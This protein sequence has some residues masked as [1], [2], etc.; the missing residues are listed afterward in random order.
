MHEVGI[1]LVLLIVFLFSMFA[2]RITRA[3]LTAPIFFLALGLAFSQS[4]IVEVHAAHDLLHFLA[5]VTLVI[6]LFLDAAQIDLKKLRRFQTWPM[7]ML[8]IGLPLAVFIGAIGNWLIYPEWPLVVTVLVAAL[9]APTDAALGQAVITNA[10]VPERVRTTITVESGLN[11][12]LALPLILLF[13]SLVAGIGEQDGVA[14]A[15]G[16]IQHIAFGAIA[17][18]AIG[19]LGVHLLLFCKARELTSI[20]Y[21]GVGVIAL[22]GAAYTFASVI[23]GNGFIAAFIAGLAFGSRVKG[24]CEFVYE[25]IEGDGQ[26]LIWA[27]FFLLGLAMLPSALGAL[28]WRIFGVIALSLLIVRPLAIWLSMIGTQA[29]TTTKLF[30]G[31][32]GPRGL[33]TAL[34][35]LLAAGIVDEQWSAILLAI[36]IN[37]VWISAVAHGVSA[38]PL[39]KLYAAKTE[40][41]GECAENMK[42]QELS[43]SRASGAPQD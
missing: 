7:R 41:M 19:L 10:A 23:G 1:F 21:E 35:A 13:A 28:D 38:A 32:F 16:A 5:E 8:L 2:H 37:A 34:F 9:L 39:S 40:Q 12:G 18:A 14:W 11:D 24:Q 29:S 33:A 20:T 27:A 42:L 15:L 36:A 31:W 30:F 43:D 17:G 4:G 26:L 22:A 25:F 3:Y 6:L